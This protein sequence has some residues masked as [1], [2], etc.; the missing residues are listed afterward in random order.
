MYVTTAMRERYFPS[1]PSPSFRYPVSYRSN[2]NT[3]LEFIVSAGQS[4]WIGFA[5]VSSRHNQTLPYW[6]GHSTA[7][8]ITMR[9]VN[10]IKHS[11]KQFLL[12]LYGHFSCTNR[13]SVTSFLSVRCCPTTFVRLFGHVL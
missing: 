12:Q 1:L 11:I 5:N 9:L 8:V 6:S 7:P 13:F 10:T 3:V 2:A 4:T